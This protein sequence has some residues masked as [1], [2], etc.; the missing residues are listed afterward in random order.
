MKITTSAFL[1][2]LLGTSALSA[3]AIPPSHHASPAVDPAIAQAVRA[4]YRQLGG[5][6]SFSVRRVVVAGPYALVSWNWADGAGQAALSK[7]H[8]QW[9]VLTAGGGQINEAVLTDYG[10]PAQYAKALAAKNR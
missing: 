3:Q 1:V 4:H 10:V 8:G 2:M 7:K 9:V 6:P 5:D